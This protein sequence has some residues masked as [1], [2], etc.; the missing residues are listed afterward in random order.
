MWILYRHS[1]IQDLKQK[2]I[3]KEFVALRNKY[4]ENN[5]IM[6]VLS[7]YGCLLNDCSATS[8]GNGFVFYKGVDITEAINNSLKDIR[9][10]KGEFIR[11]IRVAE[12]SDMSLIIF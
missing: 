11:E 8:K 1:Q 12:I 6:N 3:D 10:S 5:F 9:T 4:K 2:E 7:Q